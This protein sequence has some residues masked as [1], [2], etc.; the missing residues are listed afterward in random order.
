MAFSTTFSGPNDGSQESLTARIYRA[1]NDNPLV[2]RGGRLRFVM[3]K[4]VYR[5]L[6]GEIVQHVDSD[7]GTVT[8]VDVRVDVGPGLTQVIVEKV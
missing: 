5:A 8:I 2:I 6:G 7:D 4:G 3:R 1:E